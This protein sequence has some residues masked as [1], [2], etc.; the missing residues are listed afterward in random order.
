MFTGI[1]EEKGMVQK[2]EAQKN[3]LVIH[4]EAPKVSQGTKIGESICVD[5]VCLTV[6]AKKERTLKFEAMKETILTTTLRKLNSGDAVNLERALCAE[7]RLGGHFVSGHVDCVGRI[8]K[9]ITLPN[10]VEYQIQIEKP[11]RKYIVPKGSICI[12]GISLT[13]G[14][15]HGNYFSVYIIPYT[16][17]ITTLGTKKAGHSVNIEADILA[18]YVHHSRWL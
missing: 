2:I 5:G 14:K 7:G 10:Y 1:I 16:L 18:K 9:K 17:K 12:D 15:V 13:V 11:F 8:Q 3:L 6:S 4:I